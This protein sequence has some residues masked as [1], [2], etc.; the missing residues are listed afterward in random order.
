M[1]YRTYE[2]FESDYIKIW[3][4]DKYLNLF[5]VKV[6]STNEQF[7]KLFTET[8]VNE[9][10][11]YYKEIRSKK[12]LETLEILEQRVGE[13]KGNL[14]SSIT[15]KAIVQDANVNAAFSQAQV[16]VQKSQANIQTYGTAYAEMFKNLEIA[17]YQYLKQIPL[18]QIID[19]ASY[20]MHKIK[21]SKI[22][23]S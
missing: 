20:P 14:S 12:G 9:T 22:I 6:V 8:L 18:M 11:N 3:K 16:P 23:T 19:G 4:P 1:L 17:R 7:T 21:T 10:N 2:D 15:T 5:E 13:M